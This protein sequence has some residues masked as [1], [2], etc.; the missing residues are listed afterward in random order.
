MKPTIWQLLQKTRFKSK[1]MSPFNID[2]LSLVWTYSHGFKTIYEPRANWLYFYFYFIVVPDIFLSTFIFFKLCKI[3]ED[4]K[5]VEGYLGQ[6]WMNMAKL[7]NPPYTWAR[8]ET[9]C[10]DWLGGKNKRKTRYITETRTR[11]A[12]VRSTALGALSA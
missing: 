6:T 4:L 5:V 2:H 12:T 8:H 1:F 3:N 7:I 9:H 10:F 11:P